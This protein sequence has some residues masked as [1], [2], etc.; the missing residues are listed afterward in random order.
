MADAEA[1]WRWQHAQAGAPDVPMRAVGFHEIEGWAADDHCAAFACY[2]QSAQLYSRPIPPRGTWPGLLRHRDAAGAFFEETFQAFEILGKPGL[3]TA[4]FEPELRGSRNPGPSFHVPVYRRPPELVPLPA[5]HPLTDHGLTAARRGEPALPYHTRA[6]IEAGALAG[7]GLELLYL[8]D[9]IDAFVMHVQGSGLVSLDDG[10]KV[11][12]AFDGKNGHPYTSIGKLLVECDALSRTDAHLDGL[13]GWLR[14]QGD[15]L[16][17][18]N[19]NKSY[20]FF[21]ELEGP[22][23][24]PQGSSG[25]PLSAGRSL[26]ADPLYHPAGALLWVNATELRFEGAPLRRLMTVQDTGSAIAGPQRGD[27][28]TGTGAGAGRLAGRVRHDC[29]FIALKPKG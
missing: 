14:A 8:T 5:G 7:R 10:A 6:E 27:F 28:F 24:A 2:L 26:A 4:Y 3:L 16:A 20:I 1:L 15:P 18:L 22:A 23:A 19:A 9:L 12:L 11:R 25:V 29:Y 17:V 13:L 21:K